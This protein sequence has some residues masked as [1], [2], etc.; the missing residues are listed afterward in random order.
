[1]SVTK[2]EIEK[3]NCVWFVEV[4]CPIRKEIK[5]QQKISNVFEPKDE[6]ASMMTSVMQG[7]TRGVPIDIQLLPQYCNICHLRAEQLLRKR[8]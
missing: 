1:M 3:T 7:M 6:M 4:E 2:S 8:Q 5:A